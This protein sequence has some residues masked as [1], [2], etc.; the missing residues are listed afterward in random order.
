MS[1]LLIS[2]VAFVGV[3]ALVAGLA[4]LLRDGGDKR[5]EDR[6]EL[7]T[8][9]RVAATAKDFKS[10]ILSQPLDAGENFLAAIMERFGRFGLLFE[11]AVSPST[12]SASR[13][14]QRA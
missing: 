9:Q 4:L 8:G 12:Y 5:A 1:P 2:V 11:Q 14:C 10:S 13:P 3:A 7:L 6:L